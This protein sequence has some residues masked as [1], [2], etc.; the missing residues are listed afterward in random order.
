M[1]HLIVKL[2]SDD[3]KRL[4]SLH[5]STGVGKSYAVNILKKHLPPSSVHVLYPDLVV[6]ELENAGAEQVA[7]V[8]DWITTRIRR[9]QKL[10]VGCRRWGKVRLTV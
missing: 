9:R 1:V 2:P 7:R 10:K 3:K 8:R 6:H 4:L 5:G